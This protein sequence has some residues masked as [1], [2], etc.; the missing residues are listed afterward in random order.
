MGNYNFYLHMN[1]MKILNHNDL[2]LFLRCIIVVLQGNE[3][4]CTQINL[5]DIVRQIDQ[6]PIHSISV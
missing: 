4:L 1:N 6:Q 3:A 5:L 2:E